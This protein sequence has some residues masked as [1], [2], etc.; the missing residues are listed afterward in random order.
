MESSEFFKK[1]LSFIVNNQNEKNVF[2]KCFKVFE[3][4]TNDKE[5]LKRF[6]D[7]VSLLYKSDS[8][9][10]FINDLYNDIKSK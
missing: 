9:K 7:G 10:E 6:I 8:G 2:E 4:K 3:S 5:K 1:V